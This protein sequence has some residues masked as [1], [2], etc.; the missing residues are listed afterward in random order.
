M[1][2]DYLRYWPLDPEVIQLNHGSYGACPWPVLRA[3]DEWR[4]RME[5]NSTRFMGVELEPA[6]EHARGRLGELVGANSDDL[7]FIPNATTGVNTVLRSIEPTLQPG[8]EILTTDHDYNACTNAMRATASRSGVVV[9]VARVP[10][11]PRNGDEVRD[12]ILAAA[13]TRTKLAVI[14]HITSPTA[15]VWPIDQIVAGLAERGIDTLVDG[16]HAPGMV[17]LDIDALGAAYYTGNCHKWLC[18]PKGSG[19]LHVRRDHQAG[20]HPL[21]TSHGANSPRRDRSPFRLEFDWLGTSDPTAYLSIPAALDFMAGLV[22]GGWPEVMRRNREL[23]LIGRRKVLE[24]IHLGEDWSVR[25]EMIGSMATIELPT[26]LDP[27]PIDLPADSDDLATH[28]VD[29]LHDALIDDHRIEVPVFAWPHTPADGPPR[30]LL[31]ISAELYNSADDY[32][33]LA[34]ALGGS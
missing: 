27:R 4:A 18:G 15:L 24:S 12:A 28:L 22:D 3:Q 30:R 16:A 2:P 1:N 26:E 25:D 13:T 29:P 9:V 33:L 34:A 6:L 14:N 32:D 17:P 5:R 21:V 23:V 8:D 10:F 20:I 11:P 19:F 31:R 7:A